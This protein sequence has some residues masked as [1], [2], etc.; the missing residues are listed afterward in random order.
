MSRAAPDPQVALVRVPRALLGTSV[1]ILAVAAYVNAQRLSFGSGDLVVISWMA[2]AWAALAPVVA[3]VVRGQGLVPSPPSRPETAAELTSRL[4]KTVVFFGV[5]ESA[6]AFA[7]AALV[8]SPPNWPLFAALVPLAV[9]A[10]NL[11]KHAS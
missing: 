5:L 7:A 10:L 2:V 11:P 1:L 6:V 8:A 3:T 4:Q 9:M